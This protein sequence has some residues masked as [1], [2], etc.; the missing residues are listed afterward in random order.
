MSLDIALRVVKGLSEER[1]NLADVSR[2]SL[3]LNRLSICKQIG[4]LYLKPQKLIYMSLASW[5]SP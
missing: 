2:G 3:R 5:I 4:A 1:G